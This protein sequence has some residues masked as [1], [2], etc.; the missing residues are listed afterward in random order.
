MGLRVL[1]AEDDVKQAEIVRRYLVRDGY[2]AI[3]VHDGRAAI[4]EARRRGPDLLV[5]DVM[6][7]RVDGLDVCRALRGETDAPMLMLTARASEED[8]LLAL[9]LGADDYMTK[10]Y[11]PRELMARVRALLRRAQRTAA[12]AAGDSADGVLRTG[13][14]EVDPRRHRVAVDGRDVDCTPGE[15]QLLATLAAEPDRVF[16][17]AQL[18]T[19]IHG[20]AWVT[21]RTVDVHVM[22]LR[23]KIELDARRP[24]LL[25]T[26]FGVGYKLAEPA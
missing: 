7:P 18:L 26:V 16:T 12:R 20:D 17:R 5:L 19:A 13:P 9:D 4:D 3:V 1:L 14:L 10:P 24:E 6:M 23:K 25:L 21:E 8:L 2:E 15:F 11:S 22:N